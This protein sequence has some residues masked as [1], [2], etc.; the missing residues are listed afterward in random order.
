MCEF[1]TFATASGE[2]PAPG[3]AVAVE[4]Q[5]QLH[6]D[7][8]D[9]SLSG[10]QHPGRP[11]VYSL[12]SGG[13]SCG[14]LAESVSTGDNDLGEARLRQ[15]AAKLH[16]TQ[17]KTERAVSDLMLSSAAHSDGSATKR[18]ARAYLAGIAEVNG[19][20]SLIVHTHRGSFATEKF[21]VVREAKLT[22]AQLRSSETPVERG[23]RYVVRP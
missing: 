17:A 10:H 6:V 23:V 12:T 15:K 1:L 21:V 14:L 7:R 9:N 22:A 16:W 2:V 19:G 18:A 4:A 20:L 5:R 8:F 3:R 11:Q 13:C